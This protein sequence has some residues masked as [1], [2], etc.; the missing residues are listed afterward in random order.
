M[1]LPSVVS[2]GWDCFSSC[3]SLHSVRLISESL[4]SLPSILLSFLHQTFLGYISIQFHWFPN[5]SK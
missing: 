2:F 3:K 5:Q 4:W 1:I